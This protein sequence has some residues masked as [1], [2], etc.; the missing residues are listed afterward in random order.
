MHASPLFEELVWLQGDQR[1][2]AAQIDHAIKVAGFQDLLADETISQPAQLEAIQVADEFMY[3]LGSR[4]GGGMY[5]VSPELFEH[6][7]A[8]VI[9][10]G[11]GVADG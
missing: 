9:H 10:H 1:V 5:A 7:I 8:I 11:R 3:E 4:R 2:F 6:V